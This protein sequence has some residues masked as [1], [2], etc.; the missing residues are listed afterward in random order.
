MS[1]STLLILP[2]LIA[3]FASTISFT[4]LGRTK[5]V[6]AMLL[7]L[8]VF[9]ALALLWKSLSD[10]IISTS[11][12]DWLAPYGI[13]LI[14]DPFAALLLVTA[15][16]VFFCC[17]WDFETENTFSMPLLF[18]LQA[19]INLSF[20]TGDLFNLFVA[21]EL[22]LMSSYALI[23]IHGRT[24]RSDNLF[25]YL[26]VNVFA[27]FLY[28]IAIALFYGYTGS[29]NFAALALLFQE[30]SGGVALLPIL[31]IFLVMFIKSGVFPFYFWLPDTYPLLPARLAALFAGTL[32]K[33][34]IYAIF[35]IWL[36]VYSHPEPWLI[37]GFLVLAALTMLFG[38]MGAVSQGSFKAILCYHVLSQVGYILFAM[39]L[40]TSLA[41]TAGILFILHNMVV[42]SSLLLIGGIAREYCGSDY[43]KKMGALW[44]SRPLLGSLF[45]IQSLSLAGLPPF[46]GFWAKYM[47]FHEGLTL[48]AYAAVTVGLITSFL[49]LF[50]MIKIWGGAFQGKAE[51]PLS[52]VQKTAYYGPIILT[53]IAL[54]MG[55]MAQYSVALSQI[56]ANTLLDRDAY[57]TAGL[58]VG[59]KGEKL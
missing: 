37:N 8:S 43:L 52:S 20:I 42:K 27:S 33:V 41:V 15:S 18:L 44:H 25:S 7:M 23:A 22:M 30:H 5:S 17:L 48:G 26:L 11:V 53:L 59:A 45:L 29:L 16:V 1:A 10:G 19:G 55:L 21:F 14:V 39:T 12:G 50:S 56:A 31:G 49:T 2:F 28:L 36:T 3:L 9:S 34:G 51:R 46:S 38:V 6:R 57:I 32:S 47:L 4:S 58:K 24:S 54:S 40:S 35:R 13:V